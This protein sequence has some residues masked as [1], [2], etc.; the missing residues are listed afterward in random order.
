MKYSS[1][2]RDYSRTEE[3]ED[4]QIAGF[5]KNYEW[6]KEEKTNA[7]KTVANSW[8][9]IETSQCFK[10]LRSCRSLIWPFFSE[11]RSEKTFNAVFPD[12]SIPFITCSVKFSFVSQSR[13]TS[14]TSTFF[15]NKYINICICIDSGFRINRES[16]RKLQ[17]IDRKVRVVENTRG[18]QSK[19]DT[20]PTGRGKMEGSR[21]GQFLVFL[22]W[23]GLES[24]DIGLR[25]AA[26]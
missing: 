6:V 20:I 9:V 21:C 19:S 7:E 3:S 5:R 13:I 10:H 15:R 23:Y 11:S 18:W 24:L 2:W 26:L 14:Y 4:S 12:L 22:T 17:I 25:W 8:S 1:P 16:G